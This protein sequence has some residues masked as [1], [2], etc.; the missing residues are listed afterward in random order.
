MNH[1]FMNKVIVVAGPTASGKS[2]L[3][4]DLAEAFNGVVINAD[5]MQIYQGTPIISAAPSE[6]DKKRVPHRLYE[7]FSPDVNGSVVDWLN[8]AVA[9]IKNCWAEGKMP[10][11]VGGTGLYLDN[12]INGTTPIPETSVKVRQQVMQKLHEIGVNKLHEELALHD[13]ITANRLSLNDTTRVRRAYEVWQET[14]IA[15]SEWHKKPMIKK[16]PEAKFVV[17][18]ILP[19]KTELDERCFERWDKMMN[20]GAL[21]EVENLARL[22]LDKNLPAMK[23]LGVPELLQ[24][25]EGKITLDE[26]CSLAK[27]HTRQYAKRQMT[28]FRHQLTAD[29]EIC[30]CYHGQKSEKE[31]VILGVKKR[32]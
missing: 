15:L 32:L 4:I 3:A 10:I 2:A 22:D 18:K 28:W 13:P 24:F 5:S 26:A 7:I 31:N 16:L 21:R 12:L 6:E 1:D 8:L 19:A 25:V 17:V 23:A 29:I 20:A 27:L 30:S 14:G 11:V 9:E